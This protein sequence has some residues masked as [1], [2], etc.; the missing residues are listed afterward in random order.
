MKDKDQ[1]WQ[2]PLCSGKLVPIDTEFWNCQHCNSFY[3]LTLDIPDFRPAEWRT[4]LE[5][6]KENIRVKS[7]LSRFEHNSF[8]ELVDLY[9]NM[10]SERPGVLG[11]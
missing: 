9:S 7:L 11:E 4:E 6:R 5:R 8:E 2:C 10:I 3:P 1:L